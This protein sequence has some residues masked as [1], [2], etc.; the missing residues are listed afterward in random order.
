V[1]QHSADATARN[2]NKPPSRFHQLLPLFAAMLPVLFGLGFQSVGPRPQLLKDR[3]V[4][5]PLAFHQHMVN[6]GDHTPPSFRSQIT[7]S[8][9]SSYAASK[10]V[11]A[12]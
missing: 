3:A 8:R 10:Q 2:K 9:P 1:S 5:P 7:V 4:R 11:A 12:A 6:L